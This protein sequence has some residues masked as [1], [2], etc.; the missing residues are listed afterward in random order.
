MKPHF[1][2]TRRI[3]WIKLLWRLPFILA[4]GFL[5]YWSF[6]GKQDLGERAAFVQAIV[7]IILVWVTWTSIDR[8]DKQL[9]ASQV[10]IELSQSQLVAVEKQTSALLEQVE[11]LKNQIER[12]LLP[13]LVVNLTPHSSK[14]VESINIEILNLS[15]FPIL[16]R[17]IVVETLTAYPSFHELELNVRLLRP[18]ESTYRNFLDK[19]TIAYYDEQ[20]DEPTQ[21]AFDESKIDEIVDMMEEKSIRIE[22]YYG[23]SGNVTYVQS[24]SISGYRMPRTHYS[25]RYWNTWLK[26]SEFVY[27]NRFGSF[28]E[29]KRFDEDRMEEEDF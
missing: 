6:L 8:A 24:Y 20:Y 13:I 25:D 28:K 16:I 29:I 4:L 23:K 2:A 27:L 12:D 3:D 7:A 26:Q 22:Y 19:G 21:I 11:I 1:P 9:D 15:N 17:S 5:A 10:Q 14:S 18:V